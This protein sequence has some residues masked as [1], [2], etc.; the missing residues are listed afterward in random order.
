MDRGVDAKAPYNGFNELKHSLYFANSLGHRCTHQER[1]FSC[2][3]Y[4]LLSQEDKQS[5][6]FSYKVG[7]LFKEISAK[8]CV[9]EAYDTALALIDGAPV[10]SGQY[11]VIFDSE[12]L[13]L[14]FSAFGMCW[15]GMSAMKDIN[16][17]V[18]D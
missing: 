16:P 11:D 14:L 6:H 3:T 13:N 2:Y 10:V 4:A 15:S 7:R 9:D 1:Q 18:I 8:S 17:T 5:M 12:C